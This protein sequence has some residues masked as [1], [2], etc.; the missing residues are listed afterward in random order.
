MQR[1]AAD[2]QTTTE[3]MTNKYKT[4]ILS[5][6]FILSQT[7]VCALADVK[8][9]GMTET[10]NPEDLTQGRFAVMYGNNDSDSKYIYIVCDWMTDGV[11][12]MSTN[13]TKKSENIT[14]DRQTIINGTPK[15]EMKYALL[16]F[17][18]TGNGWYIYEARLGMY[19]GYKNKLTGFSD[20]EDDYCLWNIDK[21]NDGRIV[22][23]KQINGK[24]YI[25]KIKATNNS[26]NVDVYSDN[27]TNESI[28]YPQ[29]YKLDDTDG[30]ADVTAHNKETN[31]AHVYRVDGTEMY[32]KHGIY[33]SNGKKHIAR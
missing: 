17:V 13:A 25:F 30:I 21:G 19:I 12:S 2:I 29:I 16:Q 15:G 26:G 33:I 11:L 28:P 24:K 8:I 7:A 18:N 3:Y 22:I 32:N 1:L 4:N 23:S 27:E 10:T 20:H 31:D 5:A 6:I 9:S 14:V